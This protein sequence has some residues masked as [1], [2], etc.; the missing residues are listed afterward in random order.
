MPVRTEKYSPAK[1]ERIKQVL[2]S[3]AEQGNQQD[4]EIFVDGFKVVFRTDDV[5]QFD[6]YTDFV[7]SDTENVTVVIYNGN[8][9][10]NDKHILL[11]KGEVPG[12]NNGLD[13][14]DID[15]KINE[16]IETERQ[17]WDFD[18]LQ[19]KNKGLKNELS[20]ANDYI[21]ELEESID[22]M[23][24][25]KFSLGNINLGE[26]SSVVLE[27]FIRRNPQI[28]AK[29]PGGEALAGII[30][31]DNQE[32]EQN[33]NS[34]QTN[35][36]EPEVTFKKKSKDD[37][38]APELSEEEKGYLDFVRQLQEKFNQEQ[39]PPVMEILDHL[40]KD[41]NLIEPTLEF[42]TNQNLED[43]EQV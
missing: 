19:E 39:L 17:K 10:R 26:L 30:E 38:P 32:R 42:I 13:G 34:A 36:D 12:Q 8:S 20:E 7:D 27:G 35:E 28:L 16:K 18:Q 37:T 4:Y 43:N 29:L 9:P 6:T 24:T 11:L 25:K 14:V 23:Q 3:N 31:E 41:I 5:E 22:E 40:A 21:K 33:A 15:N 2:L 1:I